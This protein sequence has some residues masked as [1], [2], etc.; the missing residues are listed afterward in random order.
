M[1]TF[2]IVVAI[3]STLGLQGKLAAYLR[4]LDLLVYF[5]IG[6]L[7]LLIVAIIASGIKMRFGPYEIW[8]TL[9]ILAVYG[10]V[11]VRL[12]LSPEERTHLFEYGLVGVLCYQ[13]LS[14]RKQKGGR[15]KSPAAAAIVMTAIIG[16]IDEVIQ[17]FLPSRVFDIRDIGFNALAGTMAVASILV[18]EWA[19]KIGKK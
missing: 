11:M 4:D 9:G 3:Y 6:F 19:K 12:F 1:L 16:G 18:L 10:M 17:G 2:M 8:V 14:E 13:A 7:G 15:V 5:Y